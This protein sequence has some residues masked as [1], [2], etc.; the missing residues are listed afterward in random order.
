KKPP[1]QNWLI[2]VFAYRDKFVEDIDA[3]L[4]SILSAILLTFSVFWFFRKRDG[5]NHIDISLITLTSFSVLFTYSWK[6]EP[7]MILT[8]FVFLS[9]AFFIID[10]TKLRNIFISSIFMGFGILSKGV[11]FIYFYPGMFLYG[12]FYRGSKLRY[13]SILLLH[14]VLSFFLPILWLYMVMHEVGINTLIDGYTSEMVQ[15]VG[16]GNSVIDYLKHIFSFPIRGL[17]AFMPWSIF[18]FYLVKN[19]KSIRQFDN[20]RNSSLLI[21]TSTLLIFTL[22]I[23]GDGRYLL[24]VTPFLAITIYPYTVDKYIPDRFFIFFRYCIYFILFII[25]LSIFIYKI[26]VMILAVITFLLIMKF[27]ND[28]KLVNN[29]VIFILA[30]HI[31]YGSLYTYFRKKNSYDYESKAIDII[32]ETGK[33][34]EFF[35]EKGFNPIQLIFYLEKNA[36]K[37]VYSDESKTNGKYIFISK[38]ESVDGCDMLFH[39]KYSKVYIPFI[40]IHDCIKN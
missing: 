17:L 30:I 24:P 29:I 28:K 26:Y 27:H 3:R 16:G 18:I 20:V 9:Y 21:L 15:R 23:G 14:F 35:I 38:R 40:Y 33:D 2:S 37:V 1:L 4:P 22:S 10:P 13:Y 8:L 6:S 32:K 34:K 39:I 5:Y 12:F 31:V 19:L 11:S 7:D 36:G 25:V